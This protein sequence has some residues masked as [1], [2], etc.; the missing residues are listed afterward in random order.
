MPDKNPWDGKWV[1]GVLNKSQSSTLIHGY[2]KDMSQED[3]DKFAGRSSIDL[4]ISE[5]GYKMKKGSIKPCAGNYQSDFLDNHDFAEKLVLNTKGCFDLEKGK[6]YVFR[7][8]ESLT[9]AIYNKNIFG[10]ATAKSS[11]GRMDVIARLIIDGQ[12]QYD[13]FDSEGDP[14]TGSMFLEIIP[15]S[16]PICIKKGVSLNQIR[17]FYGNIEDS[18]ISDEGFIKSV[19]HNSDDG[20]VYLSVDLAN[21]SNINGKPCCAFRAKTDINE[22]EYINLWTTKT[23]PKPDPHNYFDIID[24]QNKRLTIESDR[25]Y[26]LKSKERISLPPG[27]AIYARAMD[28]TLGEMRIHYAGFAHPFFGYERS[29]G[30]EGTPLMFEVRGHNMNVNLNHG[31]RLAKLVFYKMSQEAPDREKEKDEESFYD[32]QEG[33]KLSKYFGDWS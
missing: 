17:F 11:V 8:Q 7:L 32:L 2:I 13:F 22:N 1:P 27:V 5:E 18:I 33:I 29:D 16:F 28:E 20:S 9:G 4:R 3:F 30:I 10:Q 31:E 24:S 12:R 14:S 6:C 23:D 19:L 25:F 15:I 26:L 21:S